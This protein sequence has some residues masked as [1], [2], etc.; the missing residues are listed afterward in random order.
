MVKVDTYTCYLQPLRSPQMADMKQFKAW[1]LNLG[2]LYSIIKLCQNDSQKV[3]KSNLVNGLH[4][5]SGRPKR[6]RFFSRS[7]AIL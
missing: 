6:Q 1:H 4:I 7:P 2:V 5:S 3:L